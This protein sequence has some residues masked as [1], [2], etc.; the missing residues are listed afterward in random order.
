[1]PPQRSLRSTMNSP[2]IIPCARSAPASGSPPAAASAP[3]SIGTEGS[4]VSL[5][6]SPHPDL[7]GAGASGEARLH[8]GVAALERTRLPLAAGGVAHHHRARVGRPP[9]GEVGEVAGRAVAV[10]AGRAEVD[11]VAAVGLDV[12]R[13]ER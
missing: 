9:G 5:T 8:V 10:A 13:L 12:V 7:R 2:T 1:M 11:R 6:S 3:R 4:R